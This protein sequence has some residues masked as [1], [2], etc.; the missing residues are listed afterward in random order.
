[1][2]SLTIVKLKSY[3]STFDHRF[4]KFVHAFIKQP[5]LIMIAKI[6][7]VSAMGY[8]IVFRAIAFVVQF[9]QSLQSGKIYYTVPRSILMLLCPCPYIYI[10]I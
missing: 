8:L 5:K 4:V 9:S 1:M 2:T 3:Y 10:R 7:F 6:N